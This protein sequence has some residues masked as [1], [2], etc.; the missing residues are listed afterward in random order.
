MPVP[1]LPPAAGQYTVTHG[2]GRL[3]VVASIVADEQPCTG[4]VDGGWVLAASGRVALEW[5]GLHC[6]RA[7]LQRQ[8]RLRR[9]YRDGLYATI[10]PGAPTRERQALSGRPG[11]PPTM[12]KPTHLKTKPWSVSTTSPTTTTTPTGHS[13]YNTN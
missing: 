7:P 2:R 12:R 4:G 9:H 11:S 8:Q 3:A 1:G 10:D 13:T 6:D 5:V